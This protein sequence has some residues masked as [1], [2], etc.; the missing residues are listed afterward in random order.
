MVEETIKYSKIIEKDINK[1]LIK[2]TGHPYMRMEYEKTLMP[3]LFIQKKQYCG[4]KHSYKASFDDLELFMKGVRIVKRNIS[5]FYKIVA[6]DMLWSILGFE[7]TE[8]NINISVEESELKDIIIKKIK[9]Y[10]L[11]MDHN[12]DL[13]LFKL[14]AK[15]DLMYRRISAKDF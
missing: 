10:V 9:K 15:Y 14:T 3:S 5:K 12:K 2:I 6:E 7:K 13:E 11:N 8:E 4:I 1:Y